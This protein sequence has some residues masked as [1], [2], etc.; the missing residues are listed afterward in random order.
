MWTEVVKLPDLFFDFFFFVVVHQR[1]LVVGQLR[2]R[3]LAAP[4]L[5]NL[6]L[7]RRRIVLLVIQNPRRHPFDVLLSCCFW[8]VHRP[9]GDGYNSRL[10]FLFLCHFGQ[11]LIV[12]A[13][14]RPSLGLPNAMESCSLK[15]ARLAATDS[16]IQRAGGLSKL[17]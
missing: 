17:P 8:I 16:G 10:W 11:G 15:L 1:P 5:C 9:G 12:S 13:L 4:P 7:V 6:L 14:F 3:W 2:A